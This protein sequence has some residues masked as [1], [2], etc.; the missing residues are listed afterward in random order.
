L[1]SAGQGI[2][3]CQFATLQM[4]EHMVKRLLILLVPLALAGCV[5]EQ[6]SAL[7]MALGPSDTAQAACLSYDGAPAYGNCDAKDAASAPAAGN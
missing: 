7:P 2:S 1:Q 6:R 5:T 4:G 3:L